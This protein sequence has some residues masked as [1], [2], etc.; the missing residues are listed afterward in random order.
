MIGQ[1]VLHGPTELVLLLAVILVVL[2]V[3]LARQLRR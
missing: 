2:A 1:L 3:R